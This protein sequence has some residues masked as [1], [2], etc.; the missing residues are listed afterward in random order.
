[1]ALQLQF[2][3]ELTKGS[4]MQMGSQTRE[5]RNQIRTP[6]R[7]RAYNIYGLCP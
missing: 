5:F 6:L 4:E 7:S 1:M 3:T 2:W